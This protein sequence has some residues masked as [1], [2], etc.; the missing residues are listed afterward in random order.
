VELSVR[1][2]ALHELIRLFESAGWRYCTAYGDLQMVPY[3]LESR[4]IVLVAK[5]P[6]QV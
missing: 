5:K 6:D 3:G 4:R 1:A 2:Y